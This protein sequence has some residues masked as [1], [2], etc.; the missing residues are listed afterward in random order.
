[1]KHLHPEFG[2]SSIVVGGEALQEAVGEKEIRTDVGL[3]IGKDMLPTNMY[4]GP[5]SH[6]ANTYKHPEFV[7]CYQ[8]VTTLKISI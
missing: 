8:V 6:N 7:H 2:W 4:N 5:D 1:M 3:G